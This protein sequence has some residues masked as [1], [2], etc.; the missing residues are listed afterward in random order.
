MKILGCLICE[1]ELEITGEEGYKKSVKC[2]DCGFVS[3]K[4]QKKEPEIIIIRKRI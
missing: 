3:G 2:L 4:P 1:G